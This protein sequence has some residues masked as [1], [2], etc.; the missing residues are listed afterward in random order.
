MPSNQLDLINITKADIFCAVYHLCNQGYYFPTFDKEDK[1]ILDRWED[2]LR[3]FSYLP[4]Y[5][6]ANLRRC[7]TNIKRVYMEMLRGML[8][9]RLNSYNLKAQADL[10]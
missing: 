4:G 3:E 5:G 2:H 8:D 10:N 9:K 6:K 1:E 7:N